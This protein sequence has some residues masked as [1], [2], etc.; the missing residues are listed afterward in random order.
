[1]ASCGCS[2]GRRPARGH[3]CPSLVVPNNRTKEKL[4]CPGPVSPHTHDTTTNPVCS[5]GLRSSIYMVLDLCRQSRPRPQLLASTPTLHR[6][7]TTRDRRVSL[8]HSPWR[9]QSLSSF[10]WHSSC[11]LLQFSNS[12]HDSSVSVHARCTRLFLSSF[13]AFR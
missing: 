5:S 4:T 8:G 12:K 11:W 3:H 7:T 9:A 13:H 10:S 2:P 6:S 1:M